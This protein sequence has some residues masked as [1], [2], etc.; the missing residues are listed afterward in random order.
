MTTKLQMSTADY[1]EFQLVTTKFYDKVTT[2]PY[3]PRSARNIAAEICN[4]IVTQQLVR[5]EHEDWYV[6]IRDKLRSPTT[7]CHSL[8]AP[9]RSRF[10]GCAKYL[11]SRPEL[12]AP[13]SSPAPS[14]RQEVW[15]T[16][17]QVKED[18]FHRLNS[19]ILRIDVLMYL[20]A[21]L[22]KFNQRLRFDVRR[23]E[24]VQV[25]LHTEGKVQNEVKRAIGDACLFLDVV[26]DDSAG[27]P[28]VV[29]HSECL[30]VRGTTMGSMLLRRDTNQF[31]YLTAAHGFV[32]AEQR[33]R[34]YEQTRV[35]TPTGVEGMY[36]PWDG[37]DIAL[38]PAPPEA[39]PHHYFN[40]TPVQQSGANT[41][42]SFMK[43][44]EKTGLTQDTLISCGSGA[45][46][47]GSVIYQNLWTFGES[48]TEE[49]NL[50]EPGD[51]GALYFK[52]NEDSSTAEPVAMHV[53]HRTNER[54]GVDLQHNFDNLLWA[55]GGEWFWGER[56]GAEAC[57]YP[58]DGNLTTFSER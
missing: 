53:G 41:G 13:I 7:Q 8:T 45:G 42:D 16:D 43:I 39:R 58:H 10:L 6:R 37:L 38:Y 23:G 27:E 55:L 15:P 32:S 29:A 26:R 24:E 11:L 28:L 47:G 31:Y 48:S 21:I 57:I 30:D 19:N 22:Q 49:L 56:E 12:L 5:H 33:K 14:L 4:L 46:D 51:C 17:I 54:Y 50:S 52:M 34:Y 25:I 18:L 44:G 35:S 1:K 20:D 2:V 40:F 36:Y 9:E 3:W